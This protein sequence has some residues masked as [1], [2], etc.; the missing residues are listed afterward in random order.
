MSEDEI[1]Y[2]M[3]IS[4]NYHLGQLI[5]VDEPTMDR[6]TTRRHKVLKRWA[7]EYAG[8]PGSA[9][10]QKILCVFFRKRAIELQVAVGRLAEG[11]KPWD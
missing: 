6:L 8:T 10:K 11:G 3:D 2:M 1:R 7:M 9:C 5:F 4:Q